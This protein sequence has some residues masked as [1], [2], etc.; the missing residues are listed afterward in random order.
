MLKS[1]KNLTKIAG[2]ENVNLNQNVIKI[3]IKL[4]YGKAFFKNE[5]FKTVDTQNITQNVYRPVVQIVILPA[6]AIKDIRK[7][8]DRFILFFSHG[9]YTTKIGVVW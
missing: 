9:C 8:I 3:W 4:S 7:S 5:S 2:M 6:P 1:S